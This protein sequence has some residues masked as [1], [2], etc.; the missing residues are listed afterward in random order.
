MKRLLGNVALAL[1][2]LMMVSSVA[3]AYDFSD[4][5]KIAPNRKGDVLIFPVYAAINGGW[6]TKFTVINTATD[7]SVVAKIVFR[8]A[9]FS[10]ELLDFLIYLTPTDVWTGIIRYNATTG[11]PE[12]FSDDDSCLVSTGVWATTAN[13]FIAPINT[14]SQPCTNDMYNIGYVEVFESAHT[15]NG[16]RYAAVGGTSPLDLNTPPAS[17]SALYRAYSEWDSNPAAVRNLVLV[18]DGINV[19]TGI[20]EFRNVSLN[21]RASLEATILRDYGATRNPDNTGLLTVINETFFGDALAYNKIGEVDATLAKNEL[22]M[23][24]SSQNLTFHFFTFPTKYTRRAVTNAPTCTTFNNASFLSPYFVARGNCIRYTA[25]NHDRSENSSMAA[26]II[27]PSTEAQMCDEVKWLST[28]GFTEGW[29]RYVF[30]PTLTT[31][32]FDVQSGTPPYNVGSDGSYT[33][34]PVLGTVM[35]LNSTNDGYSMVAAAH[36]DG[37]VRDLVAPAGTVYTFTTVNP[38]NYYYYQYQ[39]ERNMGT[40]YD[41]NLTNLVDETRPHP[42]IP[43]GGGAVTGT[44]DG[45]H[46]INVVPNDLPNKP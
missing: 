8:S 13:P 12:V 2:V 20:E 41:A 16:A 17:K 18:N 14:P 30:S 9:I 33:G 36:T 11:K 29:A 39:D 24:Y 34:A 42:V 21:Q 1:A 44:A 5:V 15:V 46:P 35:N 25:V 10:Q 26:T 45:H 40:G 3:M 31:T 28:F 4:H 23:Y 37:L 43:L 27:S 32:V 7:R 6:E 38:T 19:L 22:A